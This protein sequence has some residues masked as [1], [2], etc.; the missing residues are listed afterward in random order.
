ME[1]WIDIWI[2]MLKPMV[3]V[4]QPILSI[5]LVDKL[6]SNWFDLNGDWLLKLYVIQQYIIAKDR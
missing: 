2:E 3:P 6:I 1:I 4:V 5:P